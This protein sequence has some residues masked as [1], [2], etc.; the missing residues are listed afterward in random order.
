MSQLLCMILT[1]EEP[2]E[3]ELS[4]EDRLGALRDC[5]TLFEGVHAFHNFTKRRLYRQQN[6]DSR[7]PKWQ[8]RKH[9]G[10]LPGPRH[11]GA[12]HEVHNCNHS[13]G[14]VCKGAWCI[15]CLLM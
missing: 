7:R 8:K 15:C 1:D 6:N 9:T 13:A 5:L 10:G 14:C 3:E 2:S 11:L 12:R 4:M